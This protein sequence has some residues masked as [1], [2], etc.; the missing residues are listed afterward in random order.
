MS[1]L[2]QFVGAN[3]APATL[4]NSFSS[5]TPAPAALTLTMSAETLSGAVTAN[6]LKTLLT[7]TGAGCLKFAAVYA[8]D[9]TSRTLRLKITLDGTAVFD[10]TSSAATGANNGIVAVGAT[11]GAFERVFYNSS[12][13]IEAASSLSETDKIAIGLVRETY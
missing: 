10:S 13:V 12:C 1:S 6:T 5:G 2:L 3:R 9:A 8:K 4:V 11:T 7:H